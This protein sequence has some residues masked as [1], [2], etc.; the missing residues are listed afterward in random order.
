VLE[1]VLEALRG[2]GLT[3]TDASNSATHSRAVRSS[4]AISSPSLLPKCQ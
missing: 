2:L 4:A 1:Q 3:T